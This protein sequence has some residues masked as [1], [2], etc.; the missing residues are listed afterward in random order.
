[1]LRA[2][3][4]AAALYEREGLRVVASNEVKRVMR[5]DVR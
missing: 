3:P 5:S 4:R 1:V 2:N